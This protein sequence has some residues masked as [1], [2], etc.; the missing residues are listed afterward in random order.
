MART[1]ADGRA[2]HTRRGAVAG[3]AADQV[4][5]PRRRLQPQGRGGAHCQGQAHPIGG[6]QEVNGG[7]D[8]RVSAEQPVV[9]TAAGVVITADPHRPIPLGDLATRTALRQSIGRRHA[10]DRACQFKPCPGGIR[11]VIVS[12][13]QASGN[14]LQVVPVNLGRP[15][16]LQLR[17]GVVAAV[18]VVIAPCY[19]RGRAAA[20]KGDRY[21]HVT[22]GAPAAQPLAGVDSGDVPAAT[23]GVVR[24]TIDRAVDVDDADAAARQAH[25]PH[26]ALQI[27]GVGVQRHVTAGTPAAQAGSRINSR[28]IPFVAADP[29]R[30][31]PLRDL[32]AAAR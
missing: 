18:V 15:A 32:P 20:G 7:I 31:V 26:P 1:A 4:R 17:L 10:Q 9:A 19:C 30:T 28:D 12:I 23:A 3:V 27:A 24:L 8:A 11:R 14:G 16:A 13:I 25:A 6:P 29:G 2:L 5:R 22:T 21:R